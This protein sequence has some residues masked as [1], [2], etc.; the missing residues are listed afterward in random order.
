MFEFLF[1]LL[2]LISDFEWTFFR[3]DLY[4][5]FGGEQALGLATELIWPLDQKTQ[6]L[7]AR[8]ADQL[9]ERGTR[10]RHLVLTPR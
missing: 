3:N 7:R 4:N 8:A 6:T 9:K 10:N 5:F 2:I 1:Q